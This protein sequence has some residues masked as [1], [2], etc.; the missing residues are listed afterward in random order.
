M[1]QKVDRA[2]IEAASEVVYSVM[3][4]TPQ[5]NWPLLSARAG[6]EVWV[7]HENQTPAGAFKVRGGLVYMAQL[8][9]E[10]SDIKGV[11]AATRGN[12]GQSV[13]L[14]ATRHGL[15]ST[16][17]VP[18]G[19]SVEKNAS[20]RG[21]GGE[22]IVHGQDF[23]ESLRYARGL[24]EERNL[25]MV[26]S[27]DDTLVAGVASYGLEL[28]TAAPDLD[29]VYVPIGLG[30]GICGVMAAR[31]AVGSRAEIWGVVA[32]AAPAYALS[33]EAGHAV[34]TNSADTMADGMACRVPV[35]A[36]VAAINAGAAGITR[37]SDDEIKA[38]MRAY[39]S[40]THNVAEGA[41]AAPLAA[42]LKDRDR[43]Q[44]RKVGVVLSG[45]NVD[46]AVY[47]AVLFDGDDSDEARP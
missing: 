14:A 9:R 4:P 30:S 3:A 1:A 34:S 29:A 23:Q 43:W 13:A 15:T 22:L 28:F 45:G 20:I 37:V 17:V 38:A 31:D 16:I 24:A 7:K 47:R 12:H 8:A 18:H 10:R 41:G 46:M 2:R 21:W 33:F 39:F 42:L 35:D 44:G 26:Q 25:H 40:D 36:A 6:C 32:E 5:H 27:F 19:N 11:I